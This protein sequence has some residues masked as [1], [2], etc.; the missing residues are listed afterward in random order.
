VFIFI[1]AM[2]IKNLA[3]AFI[4]SILGVSIAL[5]LSACGPGTGGTGTGPST[6]TGSETVTGPPPVT[7]PVTVIVTAVQNTATGS[8]SAAVSVG[9]TQNPPTP[10]G[11][12]NSISAI[13]GLWSSEDQQNQAY[14]SERQ[15][16]F[17]KGCLYYEYQ[18]L[19]DVNKTEP[20][21]DTTLL[22]SAEGFTWRVRLNNGS[23][24]M[25]VTG[26]DG[27]ML[28]ADQSLVRV[29]LSSSKPTPISVCGR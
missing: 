22:A 4:F 12:I 14:F 2:K 18:G 23:L 8:S 11:T 19:W 27:A 7:S 15:I 24:D 6:T 25:S 16:V 26:K 1:R 9:S 3:S 29:L 17:R 20:N 10:T 28:L 21:S 5:L 13:Y